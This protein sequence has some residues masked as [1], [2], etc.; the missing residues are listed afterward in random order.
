MAA[1]RTSSVDVHVGRRVRLA[2]LAHGKS[3]E[4][5]AEA[6]D[7]TFQQLQKYENGAN[8]IGMGR[9][10]AIAKFLDEPLA[11]FFEGIEPNRPKSADESAANAITKALSTKE[12][13]RIA[14]ALSRIENLE[15]R[16]RIADLLEAMIE[17]ESR[18]VRS[19]KV[20]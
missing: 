10:H 20:V 4:A 2:R 11:Y 9:L 7:V 6:A 14:L 18:A 19:L 12:G 17:G 16:R 13:V 15:R 3:Q 8:R 5:L 1:R